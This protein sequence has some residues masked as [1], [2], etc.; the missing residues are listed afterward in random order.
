[1]TTQPR[2]IEVE[3]DSISLSGLEW[4]SN[5]SDTILAFHGWLDN[6]ASFNRLA[7]LLADRYRVLAFDLPGHGFSGHRPPYAH[8]YLWEY[9]QD[10]VLLMKALA[11]PAP[12]ILGHSLGAILGMMTAVCRP[13]EVRALALVD[14]LFPLPSP[15]AEAPAVL[16]KHLEAVMQRGGKQM[17]CY[18]SMAEAVEARMAS[19]DFPLGRYAAE[20][21]V[22]RGIRQLDTGEWTWRTD[23]RLRESSP[24]RMSLKQC[25]AFVADLKV[26]TL[27]QVGETGVFRSQPRFHQFIDDHEWIT[28]RS[29]LGG[30]HLHLEATASDLAADIQAFFSQR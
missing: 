30:H 26:D 22:G 8:Y 3:L 14:G 23:P 29:Y 1:V 24:V 17:P 4:G 16:R 27:L 25:L 7:P 13:G 11:L 18:G 20:S 19:P 10:I 9:V 28:R 5:H 12:F 21:I 6:A 2:P 15:S